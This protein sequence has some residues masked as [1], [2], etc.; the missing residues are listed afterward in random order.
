MSPPRVEL[1]FAGTHAGFEQ[2][3]DELVA[4]LEAQALD[5]AVRFDA[6]LVFE[7]V[8][9]N[10]VN[11][12]A[13]PGRTLDVRVT[14]EAGADSIVLTFDDDGVAFDPRNRP[15]PAPLRLDEERIGGFG[16]VLMRHAARS[17]DYE[18]TPAGRNHLTV[19]LRRVRAPVP[20]SA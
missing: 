3:S 2:A 9:A 11:H 13:V 15:P 17:I 16:L 19:I 1:R 6:E 18:R 12:G 14:L 4:A 10:I 8:V 5:E 20:G 7:E